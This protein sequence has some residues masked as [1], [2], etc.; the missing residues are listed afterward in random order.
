MYCSDHFDK[1]WDNSVYKSNTYGNAIHMLSTYCPSHF[2]TWW[3]PT[4]CK[5]ESGSRTYL[6]YKEDDEIIS[7]WGIKKYNMCTSKYIKTLPKE[8]QLECTLK[9]I[10]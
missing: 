6:L 5:V 2:D 1:W 8:K 10:K 4:K 3:D 9:W 7:T